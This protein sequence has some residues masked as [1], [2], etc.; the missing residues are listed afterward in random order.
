MMFRS[1]LITLLFQALLG[2]EISAAAFATDTNNDPAQP[3]LVA[4]LG[5]SSY[6]SRMGFSPDSSLVFTES[7][8]D[9]TAKL[10]DVASGA[11]LK[12]LKGSSVAFSSD[13]HYVLTGS[14]DHTAKLW[15]VC[16]GALLKTF[17]GHSNIVASVA[18]SSDG[19]LVLTGSEDSTAKLWDVASGALL[20]TFV[21]HSGGVTNVS[22]SPNNRYVLT[23]SY[24]RTAK[25][26]D[27]ASGALLKTFKGYSIDAPI[28]AFSPDGRLV[29]TGRFGDIDEPAELWDVASGALLKTFTGH[30]SA[31]YSLA[32]SPDGH[33]VLTGSYDHTA[34]L[35]DVTS[36]ALLK[37]FTGHSGRV[38]SVVFSPDG[39]LVL[40]SSGDRTSK[41][42]DVAS[43]APLKTFKGYSDISVN[44]TFFSPDGR[45]V[46]TGSQDKTAEL[47]DVA[48]GYQFKTLEGL[49]NSVGH[50]A[51]SPDGYYVL[52]GSS[53]Q[54]KLWDMISGSLLKTFTGHSDRVNSVVLSS[55]GRLV[56]I[57]GQNKI[58][59][60]WD[61][62]SD[63]VPKT[64]KRLSDTTT[65]MTFSPDGR[66]ALTGSFVGVAKLW[67][68]A[69]G[70]LL[71]TFTGHSS[72]VYRL[73][74]SPDGHYV[75]TGSTDHTAKLWD[76]TS[77]ALL[78]TFAGHSGSVIS[79]AFSP[80]GRLVVIGNDN[81]TAKLWDVKSGDLLKT[82]VGHT[83]YVTSV[84]F[85]PD[86]RFVLTGSEDQTSKI[87]STTTGKLL[88]TLISFSDDTW[89]VVDPEGRFDASNGGDVNGLHWVVNNVPIALKQLKQRYYEPG[90]LAK[91]MGFNKQPL[92]TVPDLMARPIKL[93]PEVTVE[94]SKDSTMA[95]ITLKNRGDGIGK[96]R[97]LVNGKEIAAD[98][99]GSKP[100]PDVKAI[101][102]QVEI[103]ENM[104][105]PGEENDIKVLAWNKEDW[106]SS[107]GEPVRFRVP[108]KAKVDPTHLY[109]IVVGVS[110]YAEPSMNLKFSGKDAADMATALDVS[111]KRFFGVDKAQITLL[112][113]YETTPQPLRGEGITRIPPTRENIQKAFAALKN[114]KST[115]ILVFYL[116]GHGA[117]AG[118][119]DASDY[120][121]LTPAA[122]ST[123]LSDPA[124]R[125]QYGISSAEL[126][127]W[128]KLIPALKQVMVLDTCAA[129]GAAAKLVEKKDLPTSQI[130]A[131]DRLKDRTGF[132]VLMGSASDK[133]SL[134]ATQYGQGLLTWSILQGMKG[135][136]L[137]E[138][139][140]VDVQKLFQHAADKVPELAK[141]VGGIQRPVVAA[142]RGTSFDIGRVDEKIKPLIPL[143]TLKPMILKAT[144]Q[145]D[146]E[147]ID[148]LGL[149][150][151]V[152]A[153]LREQSAWIR[154]AVEFVYVG[155]DEF[156][157]AW[158]MAGR[159]QRSGDKITVMVKLR[160]GVRKKEFIATGMTSDISSLTG[161]I[162]E[163][164]TD[165]IK[166]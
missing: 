5:H 156:P 66:L 150:K 63:A 145:D 85:S 71:K 52:T 47:W 138:G 143:A 81:G 165:A 32:F 126:T 155:E 97:V 22:F 4:Q 76:V 11:L 151:A 56:L 101:K 27:M 87:W 8:L 44:S 57:G 24:D 103:P 36:G 70:A 60:P 102:L 64:F 124:V 147:T 62:G 100:Q 104:L 95:N 51:F 161:S 135:A 117:M 109:A 46:L 113:D 12:T 91:I 107:P 2:M 148:V 37:T 112:S 83:S 115:D 164:A 123:D 162:L 67:D 153:R 99:R 40:T 29:L 65:G 144:F 6:V 142:P 7:L 131:L 94:I 78:K 160:D 59:E 119:G 34:K 111:A 118:S 125:G 133:S 122:R 163:K 114:V 139:E 146:D 55:S 49:S 50:V 58:V 74:F 18:F 134:E 16:S 132:H 17:K 96:V 1:L 79:V 120:Y 140:Y 13:G 39:H 30:S 121:Y 19:R 93:F 45:F 159:Y 149:G 152:N 28:V 53:D 90:L 14:S 25:L 42:W 23:R 21:G 86:G 31:V 89:A 73:A 110:R 154:G 33:Y 48:S 137:R 72:A 106:L 69:S 41:L 54:T 20:K 38:N 105:I 9:D 92:L 108:P 127:E 98:A 43:G 68:V 116:S 26:W 141:S 88:A 61:E 82:L 10:W 77:G 3:R 84:D 166:Q 80:D 130:R 15:D 157:G 128:I 129:G 75:L 35:W 158:Q 136:A